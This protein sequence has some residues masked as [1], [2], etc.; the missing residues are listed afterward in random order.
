MS[1]VLTNAEKSRLIKRGTYLGESQAVLEV[2]VLALNVTSNGIGSGILLTCDLEGN[3]GR[4][5]GLDLEGGTLD[6][7]VLEEEVRGGLAEVL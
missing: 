4:G 6:G 1:G 3:V 2:D 7:V 5:E